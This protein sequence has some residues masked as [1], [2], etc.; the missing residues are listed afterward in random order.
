MYF[1]KKRL[2]V[3]DVFHFINFRFGNN[4]TIRLL[5]YTAKMHNYTS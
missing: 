2:R 3:N 1:E 4:G 5:L